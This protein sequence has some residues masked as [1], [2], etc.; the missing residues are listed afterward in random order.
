MAILIR[1]SDGYHGWPEAA[2]FDR[3]VIP[4]APPEVPQALL[5]QLKPAGRLVAPVGDSIFSQELVV[6]DKF[7]DGSLRGG[8]LRR[9]RSC[10]WCMRRTDA[11]ES[12]L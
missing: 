3:I 2:P 4:A 7:T 8:R 1:Q 10:R 9:W 6:I 5:G 11:Q 12:L